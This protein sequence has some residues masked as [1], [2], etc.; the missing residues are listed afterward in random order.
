MSPSRLGL[1]LLAIAG[2]VVAMHTAER[3]G[4]FR[5]TVNA[6]SSSGPRGQTFVQVETSHLGYHPKQYWVRWLTRT[7]FYVPGTVGVGIDARLRSRRV[8]IF[9]AREQF[10]YY[11]PSED[12]GAGA[13]QVYIHQGCPDYPGQVRWEDD[14]NGLARLHVGFGRDFSNRAKT[15][16]LRWHNGSVQ[17]VRLHDHLF[18]F[19]YSDRKLDSLTA[20]GA[21]RLRLTALH[22][23][24]FGESHSNPPSR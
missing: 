18:L 5:P 8:I 20:T 6:H 24:S 10:P 11:P 7:G 4:A 9:S 22:C 17:R 13:D 14:N 12:L 1:A 21:N 19:R 16:D 2:V 15:I 3:A 23:G